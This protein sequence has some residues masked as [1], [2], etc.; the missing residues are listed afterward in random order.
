[1]KKI[2]RLF[3]LALVLSACQSVHD[4]M[5]IL[6]DV[7]KISISESGG[8]GGI[9]DNYFMTSSDKK[10]IS[11]FEEVMKRARGVQ[12]DVDVSNDKP[13]FDILVNYENGE[14]HLL[15]L[16]LGDEGQESIFM[17]VGYE[18]NGFYVSPEA[19]KVLKDSLELQ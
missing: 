4:E 18:K 16:I 7:K 17:Y 11:H 1:M 13:D 5:I 9:H 12:H 2:Y 14:R 8:Y 3:I 10:V 6:D 19:T 15:H